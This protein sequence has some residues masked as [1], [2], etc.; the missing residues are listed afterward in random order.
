MN[1]ERHQKPLK[2]LGIGR[3]NKRIFKDIED[4]AQ[5]AILFPEE[6]TEGFVDNWFGKT[7]DK[8]IYY[9]DFDSMKFNMGALTVHDHNGGTEKSYGK[10]HMVKWVKEN[11]QFE[12]CRP[13]ERIGLKEC[14]AIM[15][16]VE[17]IIMEKYLE[18]FKIQSDKILEEL[19]QEYQ[20]NEN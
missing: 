9:F 12:Y 11:L 7:P 15:D 4:A 14:K 20:I 2:S 16:R 18:K 6:Y 3:R 10:L 17:E 5:W 8:G 13:E 1:F 19:K